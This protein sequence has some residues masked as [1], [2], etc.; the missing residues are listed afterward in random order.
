MA[1]RRDNWTQGDLYEG[2]IGRWSRPVA[3]R[4]LAWLEQPSGNDWLDVGCG[5]GALTETVLAACEPR[6][7]TGIDPSAGFIEFAKAHV[8]DARVTFE[9]GDAQALPVGTTSVDAVVSGLVLNFVPDP[10]KAVAEMKRV[11]RS[12]GAVAAY[13]W[14]YADK[15]EPLRHFWNAVATLNPAAPDERRR[16]PI[17]APEPLAALF[18]AAGLREVETTAVDV[19]AA[20]RDFND[21]WRPFLGG[22]G[23]A[24]AYTMSLADAEREELR[25]LLRRRLPAQADG[26]IPLVARAWSVKGRA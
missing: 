15:M 13:V 8:R 23:P 21:Y 20:F 16:F 10:A 4:F 18:A 2:F 11:A 22:Q 5:T 25:E 9:V 12:G 19:P 17:C 1:E 6:T 26:S 24:G 3:R 7:V 14:D